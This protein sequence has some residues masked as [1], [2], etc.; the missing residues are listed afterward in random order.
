[1]LDE[2]KML[3]HPVEFVERKG[4]LWSI[5][6]LKTSSDVIDALESTFRKMRDKNINT[7]IGEV[8]CSHSKPF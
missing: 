4:W 2:A 8:K 5:I 6:T 7:S 3:G 1:M